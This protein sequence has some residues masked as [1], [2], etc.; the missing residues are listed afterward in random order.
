MRAILHVDMDAFYASVEQNDRPELRGKPLIVGGDSR[1]G[2]AAAA[3]YEARQYG[4]RS[5]MPTREALQRCPHLIIVPPRMERYRQVSEIVFGVFREYTPLVEGLSLDEAFLDVTASQALFGT[6]PVIAQR[7]KAQI[8]ERT[9]LTASVGIAHNKLLAKIASDLDKPNGLHHIQLTQVTQ[10]LDPLPVSRLPGVGPKTW[11][12]LDSA[13]IRTFGDLRLAPD[14][15]LSPL[16]G[17]HA[18]RMRDRAS[19]LDERPVQPEVIEQQISVEETYD[20]DLTAP[21]QLRTEL[22]RLSDRV[23]ARLRGKSFEG[24]TVSI[25]VRRGDFSTYTRSRS[26]EPPTADTGAI[27]SIAQILLERWHAEYP[28]SSVRLLGVGIGALVPATQLDLF[29]PAASTPPVGLMLPDPS[30]AAAR[31]DP[32]LDEI[33]ARFGESAVRRASNLDR[34][35]KNDGFSDL[36]RR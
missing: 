30:R 17:R 23:G 28:G 32:T 21:E 24:G 25:K 14:C 36:R 16:F 10:T 5:A 4:V 20:T 1:R 11:A 33:R 9:G 18:S 13:G 26:F 6:A 7:I 29:A 31:L 15:V 34:A 8:R 19:G 22:A 35:A 2:V 27:L 12:R 3:S